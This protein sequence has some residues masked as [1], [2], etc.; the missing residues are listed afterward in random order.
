M[1]TAVAAENFSLTIERDFNVSRQAVYEAWT[2]KEA[3]TEW[4]APTK[5]MSTIMHQMDLKVGGQ[6]R[7]EMLEP[8]GTSHVTHGEYVALNPFEQIAF[9]WQWESDEMEVDSLV[10]IDLIEQDNTTKMILTH[11]RLDSQHSVDLHN[12]GWTG[13]V[14]Q[15]GAFI[16]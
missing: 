4:F 10:T 16:G 15:L 3:L 6:Y 9:T 8:N 5:E 11:D 12:E 1:D 2:T 14:A 13:C 7:V